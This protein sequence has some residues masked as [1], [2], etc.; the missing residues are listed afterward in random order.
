MGRISEGQG[1]RG[2]T[3]QRKTEM[4][5]GEQDSFNRGCGRTQARFPHIAIPR[6]PVS[7]HLRFLP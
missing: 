3:G 1:D 5:H 2:E 4:N 7:G 6:T